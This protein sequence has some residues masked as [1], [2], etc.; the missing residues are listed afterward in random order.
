MSLVFRSLTSAP[1]DNFEAIAPDAAI[2]GVI[3][4]NGSGKSRLLRVAAG[5]EKAATGLV[6]ASGEVKYLGPDDPLN[7]TP[8]PILLI[9]Q[10]FARQDQV[11]RERAAVALDR[12]RRAGATV[13]LVSH[14]EDLV[15]R[16]CDEVWWLQGGRLAGRGDPAEMLAAYR[17]HV[18][19]QLRAWGEVVQTPL[20]PKVRRGDGRAEIVRVETVGE[21][22]KPTMVWRSGERAVVK[23]GVRFK[24]A[25]S[26]PVVGIMIRTRVGLNVYGTN[27]DLEQLKIGPCA[28]GTTLDLAFAFW[29]E[30]C[31]QEYTLTVASHDP[32]GVWHDWMEDA[33]AFS[34]ADGR[35]TAGVANLR[36]QVSLLGKM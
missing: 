6:K 14:E 29:C 1:L 19:A 4:E 24:E 10:T 26:D 5:L 25:V 3:G 36:A 7:L 2:I 27:T 28:P 31:P 21:T 30:L 32:D 13:M 22:G 11:V 35:Y 15:R 12:I 18:A 16:L 23:V 8:A 34:V 33:V 17:K 9:D 20:A